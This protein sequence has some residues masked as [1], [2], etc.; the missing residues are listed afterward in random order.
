[1]GEPLD[2]ARL[3]A[4]LRGRLPEYMLPSQFVHLDS[5]PLTPNGKVDR[6]ALPAPDASRVGDGTGGVPPR[7]AVEEAV[8]SIWREVLGAESVGAFD[9]FFELGGHS[10]SAA[11]VVARLR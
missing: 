10:L 3:R 4:H 8:A 9:D 2:D 11:R 1:D 6:E 7:D 5:L